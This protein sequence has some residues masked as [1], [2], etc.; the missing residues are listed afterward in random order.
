MVAYL[1]SILM[2]GYFKILSSNH[3]CFL[4]HMHGAAHSELPFLYIPK[5][6][7]LSNFSTNKHG[8]VIKIIC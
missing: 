8:G 5:M 6:N 4:C 1:K 2:L 7:G 3:T